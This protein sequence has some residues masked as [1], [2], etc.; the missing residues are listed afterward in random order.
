[1]GGGVCGCTAGQEEIWKG[2]RD[3]E[4]ILLKGHAFLKNWTIYFKEI[5]VK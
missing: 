5:S 4:K 1:M 3:L 2:L